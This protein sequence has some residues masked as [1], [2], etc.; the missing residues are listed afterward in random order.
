M[1]QF[2]ILGISLTRRHT[3]EH[4]KPLNDD[5]TT[6]SHQKDGKPIGRRPRNDIGFHNPPLKHLARTRSGLQYSF[7]LRPVPG[8]SDGGFDSRGALWRKGVPE[9]L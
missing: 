9:I 8:Q 7:L 2:K 1:P 3:S 4:D 6:D 5:E